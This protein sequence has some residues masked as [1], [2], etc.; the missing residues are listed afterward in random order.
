MKFTR[1]IDENGMFIEDAFVD[2]MTEFTI[3][4][5]C[6]S[7][8]YHPR[9]D[10]EKWVEGLTQEQI[11]A[12]RAQSTSTEPTIEERIEALE[13]LELERLFGGM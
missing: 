12:I 8:F 13:M 7:G 1:I 9:W 10:G 6:P 2:E 11:D 3:E 5:P 4:E